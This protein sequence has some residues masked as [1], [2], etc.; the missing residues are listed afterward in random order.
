MDRP[1]LE[2]LEGPQREQNDDEPRRR[3]DQPRPKTVRR[4]NDE[5]PELEDVRK[6]EEHLPP[7]G[8]LESDEPDQADSVERHGDGPFWIAPS[9]GNDE[10]GR[11]VDLVDPFV[12]RLVVRDATQ[13]EDVTEEQVRQIDE[14][15]QD[16]TGQWPA[17]HG[18][19]AEDPER[20]DEEDLQ[21]H[22]VTPE[23]P[24]SELRLER[25]EIGPELAF[26]LW[27]LEGKLDRGLEPAHRRH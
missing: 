10:E 2:L 26:E 14:D 8:Q 24:A 22:R 11:E 3:P 21:C 23:G 1:L 7:P 18:Q 4:S 9:H 5:E 19:G 16:A 17:E 20:T 13:F 15:G 12:E 25:P 27:T 6:E